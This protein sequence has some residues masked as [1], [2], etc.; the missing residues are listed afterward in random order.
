MKETNPALAARRKFLSKLGR[1]VTYAGAVVGTGTLGNLREVVA[2]S[3]SEGEIEAVRG[4]LP[5][6]MKELFPLISYRRAG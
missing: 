2:E 1:A 4:Q 6:G 3:I 5:A